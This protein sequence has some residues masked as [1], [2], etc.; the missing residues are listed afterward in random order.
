MT[1][2]FDVSKRVLDPLEKMI[3]VE[4]L[5]KELKQAKKAHR[6]IEKLFHMTKADDSREA[7]D[8]IEN[9]IGDAQVAIEKM[10]AS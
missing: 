3:K 2:K 9:M 10:S 7:L 1:S 6:E 5:R 4:A 8:L